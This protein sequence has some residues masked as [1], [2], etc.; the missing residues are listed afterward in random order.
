MP[1]CILKLLLK[2]YLHRILGTEST[3]GE[4]YKC[5]KTEN[6]KTEKSDIH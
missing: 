4:S 3:F 1:T 6:I 5:N 2:T